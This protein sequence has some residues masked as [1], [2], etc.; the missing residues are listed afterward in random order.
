LKMLSTTVCGQQKTSVLPGRGGA[1]VRNVEPETSSSGC[2]C[3][4][5]RA[6]VPF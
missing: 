6:R 3:N 2:A 1:H 4:V 5:R